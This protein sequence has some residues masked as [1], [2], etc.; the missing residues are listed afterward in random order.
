MTNSE[1]LSARTY[2]IGAYQCTYTDLCQ[3]LAQ[4]PSLEKVSDAT[5]IKGPFDGKI[6]SIYRFDWPGK[7][8]LIFRTR[9][10]KA[11]RYEPIVKEKILHP[12]LDGTI[13]MDSPNLREEIKRI[14]AQKTGSYCFTEEK[15]SVV[16]VQDLHYYYE[17]ATGI[18]STGD[19]KTILPPQSFPY[20]L[21]VKNFIQGKSFYEAIQATPEEHQNSP[22]ILATFQRA[23]ELLAGLHSV[24]FDAFYEKI[25]D[26][27]SSTKPS[28]SDLFAKQW[29]QNINRV[30]DYKSIAELM[31]GIHAFYR[32]KRNL[33]EDDNNAV[34]FHNDY[35][36][37]N[38]LLQEDGNKPYSSADKFNIN[39]VIDFDNWRI[40]PRAQ[41]FVKMEY[42]TI[43]GNAQWLQ[44]FYDGYSRRYPV[45]QDMK[46]GIALYKLLWFLVVF[47]F[48]M[49]K[50]R[51]NEQNLNVDKRFPA[52]EKYL[53][54]IRDIVKNYL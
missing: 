30:K 11:F 48:E 16:P 36:S 24:S 3:I 37:Q 40:G 19:A 50:I 29:N 10:S 4:F 32:D 5:K 18:E 25:T 15:P 33:A 52:A 21:T 23:G 27:G 28:W 42:W 53:P 34:L 8:S 45:T 47:D 39:G 2:P 1:P 13:T 38:L 14:T 6:N 9:I 41:D 26:I 51:K 35:Q 54:A 20:L 43:Q 12:L 17:P 44:A 46:D 49:D 7:E 31:P 22:A